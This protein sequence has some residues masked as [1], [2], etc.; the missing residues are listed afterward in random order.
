MHK[1]ITSILD[2]FYP[3]VK[4]FIPKETYYYAACGGGNLVLSW[5]LFFFFYQ[6]VFLKETSHFYLSWLNNKHVAISAYTFSSFVTF[7]FSFTIGFLLNRYVVF[8][9]SELQANIQLFR[10]GL[11]ALVSYSLS[12]IL[13]KFFIEALSIFPSIANVLASCIV[14]VWSYIM[15]RTFTFR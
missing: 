6:F 5:F 7:C 13:L 14:V 1:I 2:F 3:L 10:Y 15:Q 12:W 9:R 8:T 11:S 4:R